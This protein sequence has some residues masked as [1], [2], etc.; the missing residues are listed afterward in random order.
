MVIP[1]LISKVWS[2]REVDGSTWDEQAI[3]IINS[4]ACWPGEGDIAGM[5]VALGMRW[6]R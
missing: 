1:G 5:C 6:E 2:A 3:S 4:G